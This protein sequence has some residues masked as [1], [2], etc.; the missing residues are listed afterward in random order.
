MNVKMKPT[1]RGVTFHKH[2][3][4]HE[5]HSWFG[6]MQGVTRNGK[7]FYLGAYETAEEAARAYDIARYKLN[8]ETGSNHP[9]NFPVSNYSKELAL[10]SHMNFMEYIAHARAVRRQKTA[11]KKEKKIQVEAD[12]RRLQ[13]MK[14]CDSLLL[15]MPGDD[16][17]LLEKDDDILYTMLS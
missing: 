13:S 6:A 10:I 3:K 9:L 14:G 1:F 17:L 7:Q 11:R 8:E 15:G 16:S 2:T 4:M 5:A 12:T